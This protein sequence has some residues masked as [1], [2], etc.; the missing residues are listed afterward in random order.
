LATTLAPATPHGAF[1]L[2][3]GPVITEGRRTSD[4]SSNEL[5]VRHDDR[6]L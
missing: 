4:R 5:A 3:A 2:S 1:I 6:T